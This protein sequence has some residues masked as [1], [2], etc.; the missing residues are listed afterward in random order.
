MHSKVA[1]A[2]NYKRNL[3]LPFLRK[4]LSVTGAPDEKSGLVQALRTWQKT[5]GMV[6][7]GCLDRETCR[8]VALAAG[9]EFHDPPAKNM[10]V[11]SGKVAPVPGWGV[12]VRNY[13]QDRETK[14]RSR[15][16]RSPPSHIVLGESETLSLAEAEA[17]LDFSGRGAHFLIDGNGVI[18][19]HGDPGA[20]TLKFGGHIDDYCVHIVTVNPV[21]RNR[22]HAVPTAWAE[23]RSDEPR[24]WKS[25]ISQYVAPNEAQI[26]SVELLIRFLLERYPTIKLAFPSSYLGPY[27]SRMGGCKAG[28]IPDSG[29]YARRDLFRCQDGR[30][31]LERMSEV[32][33]GKDI[34][35]RELEGRDKGVS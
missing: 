35:R 22:S 5:N 14:F 17:Q 32:L 27:L 23:T 33:V 13:L 34:S 7:H 2:Y 18:I 12:E 3:V 25:W 24:W 26:R 4:V 16:R 10:L 19:Q 15:V 31:L 8:A 28:A 21:Q 30:Y 9:V 11:V 1:E 20:D 6:N 29:I